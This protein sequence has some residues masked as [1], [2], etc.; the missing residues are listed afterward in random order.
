MKWIQEANR[1]SA[2]PGEETSPTF[3]LPNHIDAN[4][5]PKESAETIAE[6]FAKISQEYTPIE[7]DK[8]SRWM[9]VKRKLELAKCIHPTIMEHEIYENMKASKITDS[10]P[11]DIPAPII[12]EFLPEFAT[13]ITAIIKESIETHTWQKK[14]KKELEGKAR[15]A[16]QLLAPAE[17]FG[18]R[19]RLFL[20][21]GQKKSL[22]CCFG[23]FLQ[24]LVSS[25][26]LG[27]F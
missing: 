8:T 13:P 22:L 6:L 1:F 3:S 23:P 16:G 20:P 11:G 7:D 15:Y 5:T 19:P 25:S 12:K 9:D 18:L 26:N 2:R 4:L 17:G 27:N 14:F 24:F 21:F 10:V